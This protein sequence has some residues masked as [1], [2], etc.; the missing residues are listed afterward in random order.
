MHHYCGDDESVSPA[1]SLKPENKESTSLSINY[2]N[3]NAASLL[4]FPDTFIINTSVA[5]FV[6][7]LKHL[8]GYVGKL[9]LII[10]I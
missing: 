7:A 6:R 2:K 10:M 5:S 1:S 9:R 3:V 8:K 4:F